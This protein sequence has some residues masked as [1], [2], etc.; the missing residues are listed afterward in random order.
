MNRLAKG[1]RNEKFIAEYLKGRKILKDYYIAP[2]MKF[3]ANNDILNLFDI[4]GI[5]Y[6]GDIYLIQVKSHPSGYYTARKE[7][8][9][10]IKQFP[11]VQAWVRLILYQGKK[12]QIRDW[13]ATSDSEIYI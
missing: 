9:A 1:K 8:R 13:D 2:V 6:A 10:W 3:R 7:L 4:I 12:K 11:S 5:G